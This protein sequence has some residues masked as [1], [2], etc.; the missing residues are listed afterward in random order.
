MSEACQILLTEAE[1]RVFARR[2][3]VPVSQWATKNLIVQDGPYRGSPLRL[4][5]SPFLAG[6]MDAFSTHGI[7]E[8]IVCGSLQVGKTLVL[9]ACLGYAM[10]YR[11]GVKMLTMPTKDSRDSV[12]EKKLEPLLRGSPTLRKL[13]SRY[14]REGIALRDGTGIILATA[15]SPSQ[16]ASIT[17]QDLIVDEEDLYGNAG[18]SNALEDFRGR[19][20]F[21]GSSRKIVRACQIKGGEESSIWR[22]I[23]E[24]A[25]QLYCYEVSC[26]ACRHAHLPDV[27]H[28][29]VPSGE[30]D[31]GEIRRRNLARY[32]CPFC[33][34][35]WTDHIRDLA[36]KGGSW[37]AYRWSAE[38][39]FVRAPAVVRPMSVGFHIPAI[40]SRMVSL[41]DLAARGL[42]AESSDDAEVKRQYYNDDLALPYIPVEMQTDAD[43]LLALRE[44]WLPARA[45]PFGAVALTCGIDV[46]KR[47]FW[48]LV[49]AWMPVLSSYVIDYGYVDDWEQVAKILF[50]TWYPVLREGGIPDFPGGVVPPDAL[51]GEVL[52]IWRAAIDSGGTETDGVFTRT[53][54]V[55]M[56]TRAYGQGTAFACKGASHAQAAPVRRVMRERMPHNGR[57]IPGGL[58]LYLLDT[59]VFKTLDFSRMLNPDSKQPLRLHAECGSDLTEQIAAEKLV[60]RNGRLVWEQ[61][62]GANHLLDCLMLSAACADASWTPSLPHYV[63]RLQQEALAQNTVKPE[64]PRRRERPRDTHSRW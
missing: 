15:E 5:V 27:A 58:P 47:G 50:N 37:R 16:R 60:R 61:R 4:D 40:L 36:V 13:V 56:W 23:T 8:V 3:R 6:P 17:V 30:T 9:Y 38:G 53:E 11:P 42:I 62:R 32:R 39:G 34:W 33:K 1:R 31:P 64:P 25:D 28:I 45:V 10:D 14:R 12:R 26:P 54:E 29:V 35:Q 52:P 48:Y 24:G 2:E 7:E 20:R 57:P 41:S 21:H 43:K 44:T 51:T 46:Q 22:G 59:G 55:Y 19:T 63:M 49:R 18:Q